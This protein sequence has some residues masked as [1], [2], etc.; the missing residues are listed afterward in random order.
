[1]AKNYM[2]EFVETM[3]NVADE[4]GLKYDS[5]IVF[6]TVLSVD[7]LEI[8]LQNDLRVLP[9][10]HFYLMDAVIVKKVRFVVHRMYGQPREV[11][12]SGN[13]SE[14]TNAMQS[15]L[16][17]E[18]KGSSKVNFEMQSSDTDF[19]FTGSAGLWSASPPVTPP[20][21]SEAAAGNLTF[22]LGGSGGNTNLD[23]TNGYADLTVNDMEVNQ[24][25][26]AFTMM[27][28][29]RD[30]VKFHI[31][32]IEEDENQPKIDKPIQPQTTVIEGIIWQ[33][34][35]VD[36]LVQMTSH[37]HGQKFMVHRI[38]NRHREN[39]YDREQQYEHGIMW[40]SRI[41]DVGIN[42]GEWG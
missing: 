13:A 27:G 16:Y 2:A 8:E 37:D 12:F 20:I 36:D 33:G 18:T 42:P 26:R 31:E 41:N 21:D 6:G 7:P 17:N 39:D 40:D 28:S 38:L 3:H 32:I 14:I 9:S 19:R 1:M 5:K 30:A 23:V 24:L 22:L 15:F 35:K 34:L 25:L 4:D 11:Q 10:R 29:V